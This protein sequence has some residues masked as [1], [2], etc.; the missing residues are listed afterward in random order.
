[1][2]GGCCRREAGRTM[3][4]GIRRIASS[5]HRRSE[6]TCEAAGSHPPGP[7]SPV[8]AAWTPQVRA[9]ARADRRRRTVQMHTA[10]TLASTRSINLRNSKR[11]GM[12]GESWI[13]SAGSSALRPRAAG[14]LL[15]GTKC[16]AGRTLDATA[17]ACPRAEAFWRQTLAA[18][19]TLSTA[20]R[21][22]CERKVFGVSVQWRSERKAASFSA[23]LLVKYRSNAPPTTCAPQRRGVSA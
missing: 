14:Q 12:N 9:Q 13:S 17:V 20:A 2:R 15:A 23:H 7:T 1:V 3:R 10:P 21:T 19:G 4:T 11:G 6:N 22:G 16:V 8:G 5:C 18:A